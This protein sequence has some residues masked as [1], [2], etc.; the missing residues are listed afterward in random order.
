MPHTTVFLEIR[1][2][3]IQWKTGCKRRSVSA[4][5]GAIQVVSIGIF[6]MLHPTSVYPQVKKTFY[7]LDDS[8]GHQ[9]PP[10][11]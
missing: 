10:L 6:F 8:G 7:P 11:Q 9:G 3:V 4:E 1:L 5:K 2:F